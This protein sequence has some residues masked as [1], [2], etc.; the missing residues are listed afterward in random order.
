MESK[1]FKITKDE[2]NK[3][4]FP[5]GYRQ[6]GKE[7]VIDN[8]GDMTEEDCIQILNEQESWFMSTISRSPYRKLMSSVDGEV[9]SWNSNGESS[10]KLSLVPATNLKLFVNYFSGWEIRSDADA[11][12]SSNYTY[13]STTN[14][15]SF[16]KIPDKGSRIV[17]SYDHGAA[18]TFEV[19]KNIIIKKTC[20]EIS[21]RYNFFESDTNVDNRFDMWEA[22]ANAQALQIQRAQMGIVELD[23]IEM[24]YRDQGKD[25]LNFLLRLRYRNG[26]LRG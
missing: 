23:Q 13:N 10:Y 21:R 14:V 6:N 24:V 11:L 1:I 15:L 9:L 18:H 26:R 20:V 4:L 8:G 2:I 25:P 12:D 16:S 22:S 19:P 3:R 7:F 17:V 5:A